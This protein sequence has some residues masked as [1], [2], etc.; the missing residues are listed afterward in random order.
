MAHY[1]AQLIVDAESC[2]PAEQPKRSEAAADAILRLWAHRSQLP[3]GTRPLESLEPI[4]R[5]LESLDPESPRGRFSHV[6]PRQAIP[7]ADDE[8]EANKWLQA[9]ISVDDSAR[10]LMRSFLRQ[11][12]YAALDKTKEWVHLATEAGLDDD[13]LTVIIK[14]I[15]DDGSDSQDVDGKDERR[16]QA[17]SDIERLSKFAKMAENI[18]EML[19]QQIADNTLPVFRADAN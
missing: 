5:S 12:A 4:L 18:A 11:A 14:F 1:I 16:K 8:A 19:R 7:Q 9:A 6:W 17:E 2:P 15:G 13:R 3:N 10:T